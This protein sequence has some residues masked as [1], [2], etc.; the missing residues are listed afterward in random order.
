MI[1][2]PR[3]IRM[4]SEVRRGA[5]SFCHSWGE[6]AELTTGLNCKTVLS[7]GMIFCPCYRTKLSL[8]SPYGSTLNI[9]L[10][11]D[12]WPHEVSYLSLLPYLSILFFFFPPLSV[13]A[14]LSWYLI[15][16]FLSHISLSFIPPQSFVWK[17]FPDLAHEF[18]NFSV[19]S[20]LR[21]SFWFELSQKLL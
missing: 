18:A 17:S 5:V 20:F 21:T 9:L 12:K 7:Q 16:V 3:S 2:L 19:T 13:S 4:Q 10:F 14:L 6:K 15:C 1:S 11:G 8:N